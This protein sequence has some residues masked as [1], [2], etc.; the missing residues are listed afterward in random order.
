MSIEH[1]NTLDN[2]LKFMEN[3]PEADREK[4]REGLSLLR[5]HREIEMLSEL[6]AARLGLSARQMETLEVLFHHL[7]RALTPAHLA[8]RVH[9]TRSAMTS[10]LDSLQ[11]KG[12]LR[13]ASHPKD[14]RMI[15]ITLTQKGIDFCNKNLPKRY[16]DIQG[17]MGVL[18][19]EERRQL[20]DF[21]DRIILFLKEMSD[22]Q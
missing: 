4:V 16:R 15:L 17:V 1:E 9:L 10:N 11:H 19:P 6:Y 18:S 14:R 12:Y 7:D 22:A 8:D 2:I 20:K 21:Y 5:L 13:R 3:W